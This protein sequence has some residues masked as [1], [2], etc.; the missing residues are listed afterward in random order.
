MRCKFTLEFLPKISPEKYQEILQNCHKKIT[1][2]ASQ[3]CSPEISLMAVKKFSRN[4]TKYFS[5]KASKGFSM[6]KCSQEVQRIFFQETKE[7]PNK[8]IL[9]NAL[10]SFPSYSLEIIT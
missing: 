2:N 1:I 7:I 4:A 10:D 3:K 6:Q 8:T 5:S 9:R